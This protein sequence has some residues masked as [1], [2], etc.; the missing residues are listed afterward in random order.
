MCGGE[1]NDKMIRQNECMC[2]RIVCSGFSSCKAFDFSEDAVARLD[3]TAC[4]AGR[5]RAPRERAVCMTKRC[6]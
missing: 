2:K 1:K 5:E 6:D 4:Q 3:I